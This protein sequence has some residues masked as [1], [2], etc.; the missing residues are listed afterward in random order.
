MLDGLDEIDWSSL[1]RAY[2]SAADVP[3]QLRALL[4]DDRK[5]RDDAIGALFSKI[6]HQGTVY[7][8]SSAALPFLYESW[9]APP[10]YMSE[11]NGDHGGDHGIIVASG[12]PQACS[13]NLLISH[14]NLWR[15]R[16]DSNL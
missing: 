14:W 4:S 13:A 15:S 7:P 10:M 3:S 8:A 1:R 9:I 12:A 5:L 6:Y 2:G 11:R 16:E